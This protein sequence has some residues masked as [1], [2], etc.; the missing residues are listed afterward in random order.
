[1]RALMK[2]Y[3]VIISMMIFILIAFFFFILPR[4]RSKNYSLAAVVVSIVK[5]K[6][7]GHELTLKENAEIRYMFYAFVD[8]VYDIEVGDS[9]LKAANNKTLF[10]KSKKDGIIREAR[11]QDYVLGP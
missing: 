5:V 10:V 7:G 6:R 3:Y 11:D 8:N 9:L 4:I 2:K 1:M